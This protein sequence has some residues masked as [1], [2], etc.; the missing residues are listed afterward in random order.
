[1]LLEGG[2][3]VAVH[4]VRRGETLSGIAARYGTTVADLR[5]L[6]GMGSR[7]SLIRAGQ[8]LQVEIG[9][10]VVHVVRRGDTLTEIAADYG[11][12]LSDLLVVNG[13]G[14]RTVIRPGQ[15]LTV[16]LAN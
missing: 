2:N 10:S 16:P 7:Q 11:V 3:P 6:N 12:P 13:L 14:L 15:R 8:K 9:D 4:V 1:M 5:D